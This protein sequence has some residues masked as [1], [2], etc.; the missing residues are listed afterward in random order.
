[1]LARLWSGV[2]RLIKSDFVRDHQLE[3]KLLPAGSSRSGRRLDRDV[4]NLSQRVLLN[5]MIKLKV[6]GGE[7]INLGEEGFARSESLHPGARLL[8]DISDFQIGEHKAIFEGPSASNV[9]I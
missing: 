6:I 7:A 5:H 3:I 1:M 9:M 8:I 2:N 4:L